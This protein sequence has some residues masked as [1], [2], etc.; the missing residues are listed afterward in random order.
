VKSFLRPLLAFVL[1]RRKDSR[2]QQEDQQQQSNTGPK[3]R[4]KRRGRDVEAD[5]TDDGEANTSCTGPEYSIYQEGLKQAAL[6]MQCTNLTLWDFVDRS[7]HQD[8]LALK[9][10]WQHQLQ[11]RKRKKNQWKDITF[12]DTIQG[13]QY[14]RWQYK[15]DTLLRRLKKSILIVDDIGVQFETRLDISGMT[16]KV[17][18]AVLAQVPNDLDII[19]IHVC[20]DIP[21]AGIPQVMDALVAL[22]ERQDRTWQGIFVN[23]TPGVSSAA[24]AQSTTAAATQEEEHLEGQRIL[25]KRCRELQEVTLSHSIPC[26]IQPNA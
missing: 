19:Q 8:F 23:L 15:K 11:C 5:P 4:S 25:K 6:D 22:I 26:V 7:D 3:R 1:N 14:R 18:L 21:Y 16:P 20:G 2:R 10:A 12:V 24:V 9:H 17:I 13:S